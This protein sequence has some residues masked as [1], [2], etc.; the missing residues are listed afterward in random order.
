MSAIEIFRLQPGQRM[1]LRVSC[2][3]TTVGW[4]LEVRRP[5]EGASPDLALRLVDEA[6]RE[7][8][9]ARVA[10]A[11]GYLAVAREVRGWLLRAGAPS[12][13]FDLVPLRAHGQ[14]LAQTS[15]AD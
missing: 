7:I 1:E 12:D 8:G 10:L 4:T 11:D 3:G 5:Q 6:S 15:S 14:P 13:E 9:H 2:A